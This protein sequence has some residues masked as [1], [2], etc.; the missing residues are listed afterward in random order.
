MLNSKHIK[1]RFVLADPKGGI[2][3]RDESNMIANTCKDLLKSFVKNMIT[4]KVSD[5]LRMRTPAFIHDHQT[6]LDCL[7]YEFSYLE[8]VLIQL[9]EMNLL[10]NPIE[11]LKWITVA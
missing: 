8:G 4:G 2:T 11:R 3:L 6:Y 5:A 7:S 10:E 1:G 9:K